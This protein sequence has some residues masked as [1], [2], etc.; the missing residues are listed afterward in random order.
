MGTGK[1]VSNHTAWL[2]PH[3]KSRIK[4]GQ[5]LAADTCMLLV[6]LS[7][8]AEVYRK[9]VRPFPVPPRTEC[10]R[11]L[12]SWCKARCFKEQQNVVILVIDSR[13]NPL[14]RR[15]PTKQHT[16]AQQIYDAAC[17]SVGSI[18][19]DRC[20][21]ENEWVQQR[22]KLDKAQKTLAHYNQMLISIL[23]EWVKL[24]RYDNLLS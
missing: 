24:E 22:C 17:S 4:Q 21:T 14:K 12:D 6:R 3:E 5:W 23:M 11:Y 8:L 15:E 19:D 2:K 1:G 16:D 13:R 20:L 18:D 9:I 10:F 7:C